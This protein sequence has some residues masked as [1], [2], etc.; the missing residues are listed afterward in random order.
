MKFCFFSPGL[1][2]VQVLDGDTRL[3]GGAEAQVARLAAAFSRQGHQVDLIYGSGQRTLK[4]RMLDGVR[5]ID[6]APSWKKPETLLHFWSTLKALRPDMIYAR[7][8]DDFLW[9]SGLFS[10]MHRETIFMYAVAHDMQC[11]PWKTYSY[12]KWFH[13]SL[14]ALGMRMADVVALQHEGQAK[15]LRPYLRTNPILIP[16][17]LPHIA[18][19]AR[20]YDTATIDAIWIAKIREDKQLHIFLDV[21]ERLPEINFAI[22][23]GFDVNMD[24]RICVPLEQ[25]IKTLAN[26]TFFG[27][28]HTDEVL[29]LLAQSKILVNTS[30]YEGFPNTMLEAWGYGVPVV[31]LTVDPGQVIRREQIGLVSGTPDQLRH[32]VKQLARA[33]D[34][35]SQMGERGLAYVRRNHS[36]AMVYRAFEQIFPE[37]QASSSTLEK[38]RV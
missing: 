12:N 36:L 37:L 17:L 3:S 32:D 4:A 5:C 23:G 22:V 15:L 21:V 25:R 34:L 9:I 6:A 33:Q 1:R 26:L 7:L 11:N 35:N 31:S 20:K 27:P 19:E 2:S 13:N 28:L 38:G 10:K 8:P 16:N 18:D 14:Y 29:R 30:I 24:R